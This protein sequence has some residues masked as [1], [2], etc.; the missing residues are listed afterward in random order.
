MHPLSPGP[1]L[2]TNSA[3][4][5]GS[6]K[7]VAAQIILSNRSSHLDV[8]VRIL[9]NF[10]LDLDYQALLRVTFDRRIVAT[11][12]KNCLSDYRW[13]ASTRVGNRTGIEGPRPLE[14]RFELSPMASMS[15]LPNLTEHRKSLAVALSITRSYRCPIGWR[16]G[17]W[18]RYF[19][20]PSSPLK[21]WYLLP[22][23]LYLQLCK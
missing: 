11:S 17:E 10:L 5:P 7:A 16:D 15:E 2:G 6:F 22:P 19:V 12:R 9:E 8:R 4:A 13:S 20:S 21:Q 3:R 23:H 1:N 14:L 18:R